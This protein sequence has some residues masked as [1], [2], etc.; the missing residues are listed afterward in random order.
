MPLG[1]VHVAQRSVLDSRAGGKYSF[2]FWRVNIACAAVSRSGET[3]PGL[4]R[5]ATRE[6]ARVSRRR[7]DVS[8]DVV[9]AGE[10][11][12]RL[13]LAIPSY[14]SFFPRERLHEI[15]GLTRMAEDAGVDT[16]VV[17]DH[18]VMSDRTDRYRWGPFPLPV[19]AP[20]LEPLTVLAAIA[21]ATRRV[22]LAT[23]IL[24]APLRPAALLAKAAATLDV[25]SRGRLDL[26]VGT[27]WQKEEFDAVRLD[28]GRRGQ[29]LDDAIAACRA[30]WGKS[31]AHFD[32]ETVRFE[33]IWCEPKPVQP[34]GIPVWFSGTLTPRTLDRVI[35]LGDGWI[36]IMGENRAGFAA[37]VAE[38]R[39]GWTA[40]GRDPT[41]LRVRGMLEVVRDDRRRPHLARTLAGAGEL[42]ACG[43]T[44]VQLPLLAF[45]RTPE[46]LPA[47]FDELRAAWGAT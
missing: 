31:P 5:V 36:P 15:V 13:A 30:L 4:G 46:H 19:D 35:R 43:A 26:G 40:A 14:G 28:Y 38:L 39:R 10:R 17:P 45:V 7:T 12:V 47:F 20:W 42:A 6:G 29:L 33:K 3:V 1:C 34:G 44:E 21:G 2:T 11:S 18:L 37:G 23:G 24:I 16:V 22:R 32:S 41:R 8:G 25:L 9:E 27:G